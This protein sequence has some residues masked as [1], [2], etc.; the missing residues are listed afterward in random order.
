MPEGPYGKLPYLYLVYLTVGLLW[1]F[2]NDRR[3]KMTRAGN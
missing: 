3:R 2:L 1:F